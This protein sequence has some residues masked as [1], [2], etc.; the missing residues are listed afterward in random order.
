MHKFQYKDMFASIPKDNLS[1]PTKPN[2]VKENTLQSSLFLLIFIFNSCDIKTL[3]LTSTRAL[4][5]R[6]PFHARIS[7]SSDQSSLM[8]V[9]HTNRSYLVTAI[10]KT[11]TSFSN[12]MGISKMALFKTNQTN[13]K[14]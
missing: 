4:F 5:K 13:S 8:V 3:T 2:Y 10:P 12:F 6:Q 1:C 11:L 14:Y 7:I 9:F